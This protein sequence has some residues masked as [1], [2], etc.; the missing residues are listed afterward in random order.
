[1][2]ARQSS[3]FTLIEILVALAVIAISLGAL[4]KAAG[5]HTL[6]A[7]QLKNK[8]LAHYV[9]L[10]EITRLQLQKKAPELGKKHD[11]VEMVG[12]EWFWTQE[13]SK[14]NDETAQIRSIKIT[15][16]NDA[17]RERNLVS[18]QGYLAIEAR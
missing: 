10:N 11:S 17:D 9:A 8:T 13:V 2:A 7:S 14:V 18:V 15:V 6:S 4:M 5:N 16:Y 3:G 12:R 1:M